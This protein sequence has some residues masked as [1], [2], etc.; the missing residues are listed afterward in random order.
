MSTIYTTGSWKPKPGAEDAFI[1]AWKE[2]AEWAASRP[3][4][5]TLHLARDLNEAGRFVSFADWENLETVRA[6]KSTPEFADG[7]A[8]VRSHVDEFQPT[9]L[10][11]VVEVSAG[12]EAPA[13]A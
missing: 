4:V 8:R 9:E 13:P 11:V 10:E 7:L 5:G 1:E 3:G 12:K 6:W 2:F